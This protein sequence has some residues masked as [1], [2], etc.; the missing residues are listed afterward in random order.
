M[1]IEADEKYNSYT[2]PPLTLQ[3]LLD[4]AIKH[5]T[6]GKEQPLQICIATDNNNTLIVKN[7][8]QKKQKSI[9]NHAVGL[10]SLGS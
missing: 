7:N 1:Q 4:N 9:H 2:L 8:L 6:T 10:K 3:L 5:N